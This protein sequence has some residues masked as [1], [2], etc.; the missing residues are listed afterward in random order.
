MRVDDPESE[1]KAEPLDTVL[2]GDTGT[3]IMA[4]ALGYVDPRIEKRKKRF[5]GSIGKVKP[6]TS[7]VE[8]EGHGS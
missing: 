4:E 7:K 1:A 8:A 5:K 6:L 3:D 2:P